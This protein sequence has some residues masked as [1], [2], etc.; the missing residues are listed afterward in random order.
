M[1]LWLWCRSA[2]T[3]PIGPLAWEAQYAT[4][5]ALKRQ[6][7]QKK[8]KKKE[9]KSTLYHGSFADLILDLIMFLVQ[10]FVAINTVKS[11]P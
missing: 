4:D 11:G 9:K 2:A 7:D 3:T 6:K 1:L 10:E 5:A 8:K